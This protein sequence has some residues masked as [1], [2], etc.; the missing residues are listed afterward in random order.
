MHESRFDCEILISGNFPETAWRAIHR[1]QAAHAYYMS[2]GVFL[3]AAPS[4]ETLYRQ[5]MQMDG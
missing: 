5:A 1:R 2:F 4:G 3:G